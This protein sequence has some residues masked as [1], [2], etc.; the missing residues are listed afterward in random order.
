[1]KYFSFTTNGELDV[2]VLHNG[3]NGDFLL[4][5]NIYNKFN[6][7]EVKDLL[8]E[9]LEII[10]QGEFEDWLLDAIVNE[11]KKNKMRALESNRSRA[12]DMVMAFTNDMAW[13]DYISQIKRMEKVTKEEIVNFAKAN[14]KDNYAV[15]YKRNGEDPNKMKVDKPSITKVDVDRSV[16]SDFFNRIII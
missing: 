9:Q 16:Q 12:N 10:K 11:F 3:V 7:E 2:Q 1:M 8:L 14:Y 15:V 5:K 4:E 13:Q 6:K